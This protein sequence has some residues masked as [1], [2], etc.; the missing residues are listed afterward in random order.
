M[1]LVSSRGNSL[2]SGTPRARQKEGPQE[3]TAD[4]GAGCRVKTLRRTQPK[5]LVLQCP[6]S[7]HTA[8]HQ[9][10]CPAAARQQRSALCPELGGFRER[11]TGNG[12]RMVPGD[13]LTSRS[14][15]WEWAA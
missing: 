2:G 12:A 11:A 8:W 4:D 9:A 6:P 14:L 15:A 3:G 13:L 1:G 7:P 10:V 5:S